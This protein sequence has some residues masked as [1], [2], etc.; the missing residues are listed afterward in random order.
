MRISK[1]IKEFKTDITKP[2]VYEI[3]NTTSGKRYIGFT[4]E[5]KSRFAEHFYS[6][7]KG[8]H[9]IEDMQTDYD[10]GDEFEIRCLCKMDTKFYGRENRAVESLFILHYDSVEH[11]YNKSYNQPTKKNAQMA[12]QKYAEYIIECL[13]NNDIS[14]GFE[15][16]P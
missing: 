15:I 9:Y 2:C 3:Y 7:R 6:L 5:P 4:G 10:A 8:N 16:T 12:I 11:G 13:R 1:Q 14:F